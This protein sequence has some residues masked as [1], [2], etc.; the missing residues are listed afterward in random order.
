M[1]VRREARHQT[2]GIVTTMAKQDNSRTCQEDVEM[3]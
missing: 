2:Q 1:G 3:D